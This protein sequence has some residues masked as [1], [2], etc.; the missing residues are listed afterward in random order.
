MTTWIVLA[1]LLANDSLGV[2]CCFT[3]KC[4]DDATSG[5]NAMYTQL[6]QVGMGSYAVSRLAIPAW[7]FRR[8]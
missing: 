4:I 3:L 5:K 8:C 1:R 2:R 7:P 6:H